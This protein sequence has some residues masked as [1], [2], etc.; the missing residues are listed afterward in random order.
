[1]NL[2]VC[3]NGTGMGLEDEDL[4]EMMD[5]ISLS[6]DHCLQ[7]VAQGRTLHSTPPPLN[8]QFMHLIIG[9]RSVDSVWGA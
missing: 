1:M 6:A 4:R 8:I 7:T 2:A 5:S 3:M 9:F